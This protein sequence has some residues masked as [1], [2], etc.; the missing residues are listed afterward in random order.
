[1]RIWRGYVGFRWTHW[2]NIHMDENDIHIHCNSYVMILRIPIWNL[3]T[4]DMS[5]HNMFMAFVIHDPSTTCA[6]PI[7]ELMSIKTSMPTNDVSTTFHITTFLGE[8]GSTWSQPLCSLVSSLLPPH[9]LLHPLSSSLARVIAASPGFWIEQAPNLRLTV[10]PMLP[11]AIT[12]LVL[13][14]NLTPV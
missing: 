6:N 4:L 14:G 11:T 8:F 9:L 10:H 13:S 1:M 3:D 2:T 5:L 7:R 12:G